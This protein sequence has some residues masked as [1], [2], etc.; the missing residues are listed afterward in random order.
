MPCSKY[1]RE[2]RV[3][4]HRLHQAFPNYQQFVE[5]RPPPFCDGSLPTGY[6]A[7]FKD[8]I[9]LEGGK[10]WRWN[11][12]CT[13]T[14]IKL[15]YGDISASIFK[16]NSRPRSGSGTGAVGTTFKIWMY[17]VVI[18]EKQG[19]CKFAQTFYGIWCESG[20]NSDPAVPIPIQHIQLTDLAFLKAFTSF[21]IARELKAKLIISL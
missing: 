21:D 12:S 3:A 20:L 13:I 5:A 17:E 7:F 10:E 8:R 2:Q 19:Q 6:F 9:P 18:A 16:L 14:N 11:Q 15:P 1:T 4:I